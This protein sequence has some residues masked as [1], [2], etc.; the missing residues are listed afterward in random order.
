MQRRFFLGALASLASGFTPVAWTQEAFPSKP[1]RFIVP[2]P[3]G[4]ASDAV[5]RLLAQ[6][7]ETRLNQPVL[8]INVPGAGGNIGTEQVKIAAADGHTWLMGFDGTMV[9][10][11]NL[12]PKMPFDSIRDFAPVAK[13]GD[14][15]LVIVANKNQQIANLKELVAV[16]KERAEGLFY[17]TTGIGSTAHIAGE[18][19]KQATSAKL[20]HVAYKGAGPATLDVVGGHIPLAIVAVASVTNHVKSG[21]L[22]AIA[23]TGAT[24][25]KLLPDVPTVAESGVANYDITSWFGMF[26]PVHTPT[27]IVAKL[28]EE[29]NEQLQNPEVRKQIEDAGMAPKGG[30]AEELEAQVKHD[31][32]RYSEIV[33]S[34]GIEVQK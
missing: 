16:S 33:K 18:L 23:I 20:T 26:V 29:L 22:T 17:G 6:K 13:I 28:N 2:F 9:I 12:M 19:L 21:A 11:P 7:M 4:G 24:R 8:V 25:S 30:T 5:A 1:I 27:K 10:N 15:D 3:P 14:V 31:L 32:A 34:A